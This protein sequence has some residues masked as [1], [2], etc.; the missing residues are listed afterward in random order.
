ME[1]TNKTENIIPLTEEEVLKIIKEA[2]AAII[3]VNPFQILI[4]LTKDN[5]VDISIQWDFSQHTIKNVATVLKMLT[6]GSF[7]KD[8]VVALASMGRDD[9]QKMEGIARIIKRWNRL[10]DNDNKP[11][12]DSFQPLGGDFHGSK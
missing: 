1:D 2:T 6:D 11:Y 9:N 8:I 10:N 5:N 3:P 12:I 4:A 7:N